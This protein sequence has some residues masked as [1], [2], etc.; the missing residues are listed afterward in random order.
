MVKDCEGIMKKCRKQC[1]G[2]ILI[3]NKGR[4]GSPAEAIVANH[5]SG[6]PGT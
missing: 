2:F 3:V 1:E 6:N 5:L 4:S